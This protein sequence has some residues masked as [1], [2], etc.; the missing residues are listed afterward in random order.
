MS[1][2]GLMSQITN[3]ICNKD[4]N[5]DKVEQMRSLERLSAPFC[6]L[7]SSTHL[8]IYDANAWMML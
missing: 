3:Q 8:M 7:F 2:G 4:A 5:Y 6:Y 1:E